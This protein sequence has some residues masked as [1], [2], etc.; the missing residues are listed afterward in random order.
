MAICHGS[1]HNAAL[2]LCTSMPCSRRALLMLRVAGDRCRFV[3]PVPVH[4]G[5]TALRGSARRSIGEGVASSAHAARRHD[6]AGSPAR[7]SASDAATSGLPRRAPIRAVFL[8]RVD[9]D[10]QHLLVWRSQAALRAGLSARRRSRRN[11]TSAVLIRERS[12]H[13][14]ISW[15]LPRRLVLATAATSL[16]GA[17]CSA[18]R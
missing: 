1:H 5:G 11:R 13:R 3:E 16:P 17:E 7:P 4:R 14:S 10:R 8:R 2:W 6:R 12:R 15:P 18:I 9:V